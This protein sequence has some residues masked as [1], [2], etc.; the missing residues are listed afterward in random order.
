MTKLSQ[1]L[2]VEKGVKSRTL[3]EITELYHAAQKP[4]IWSG[5]TRTYTPKDDEGDRLPPEATQVQQTAD[6]HLATAAVTLA[7]LFDVVA[8]K[9]AANQTAA[10]DVRIDGDVILPQVPVT[11]L[12]FL[13]KQ[14]T[15]LRTFIAEIPT[16][17]PSSQWE[18]D[19]G[20]AVYRTLP[21]QTTK[22]TKV[23]RNHVRA[24]ATKEHPA[25][26]DIFTEDVIVGTW[27]TYKLSG[28]L[29]PARKRALLDRVDRLADAVKFAREEANAV[30]VRDVHIG[31]RVFDHLLG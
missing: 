29:P 24:E 22:T 18:F 8:T 13:E 9:D 4:A 23:P 15:D 3:S 30:E 19:P 17:D 11:T 21:V 5:I 1:L 20:S 7:R 25:Q 16:L 26:V 6:T 14:L 28:G 27:T 12:L 10:A 2:A 31:Q